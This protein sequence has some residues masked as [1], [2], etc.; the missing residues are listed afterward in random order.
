MV[1]LFYLSE[2]DYATSNG[3]KFRKTDEESAEGTDKEKVMWNSVQIVCKQKCN[4]T[5]R[6]KEETEKEPYNQ[7]AET[8][9]S[10]HLP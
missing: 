6:L 4:T 3:V 2:T 9:L 1:Q 10:S 7:K 5:K 8:P